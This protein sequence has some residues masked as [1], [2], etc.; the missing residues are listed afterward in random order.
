L[1]AN[2]ASN[3]GAFVDDMLATGDGPIA[4]LAHPSSTGAMATR[5]G[6]LAGDYARHTQQRVARLASCPAH[7]PPR[8]FGCFLQG[9]LAKQMEP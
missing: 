2:Q 4:L 9:H 5:E 3:G 1:S 8:L 6:I 7:A